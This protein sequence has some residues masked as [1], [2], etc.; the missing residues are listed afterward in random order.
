MHSCLGDA[1]A[2]AQDG[3]PSPI[4]ETVADLSKVSRKSQHFDETLK[5][6]NSIASKDK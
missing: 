3:A 4:P 1:V 2:K 6:S 5:E